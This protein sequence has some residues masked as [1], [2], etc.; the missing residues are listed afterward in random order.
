MKTSICDGKSLNC[1]S[2]NSEMI[3]VISI[4]RIF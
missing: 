3:V 1:V 2:E 4:F